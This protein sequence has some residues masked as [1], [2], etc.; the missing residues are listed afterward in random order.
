[1]RVLTFDT[2]TTGLPKR[3]S[4]SVYDSDNWPHIVQLSMLLYDLD[5]QKTIAVH[6]F[7][8]KLPA[9]VVITQ[10][11]TNIHGITN[12]MSNQKGVD[13]KEALLCMS[14]CLDSAQVLVAHNLEFDTNMIA[15]ECNR[16]G[17]P[18]IFRIKPFA[19]YCT[20]LHGMELCNLKMISRR[21]NREIIKFPKL[22]ELYQKLFNEA[23]NNLHN[24]LVDVFVCFRCYHKLTQ[25]HDILATDQ[26]LKRQFDRIT[27]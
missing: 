27:S 17:Y 26:D 15:A 24:S 4:G 7:I 12:E 13:I 8:I 1:M 25:V 11:N 18:S 14:A 22:I 2:E 21:T 5:A 3:Y 20:M 10:E 16:V 19:G 6:D 23:P 9:N